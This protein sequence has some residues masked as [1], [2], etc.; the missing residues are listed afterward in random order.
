[1]CVRAWCVH[2]VTR[3]RRRVHAV[4]FIQQ[5]MLM[6]HVVTSFAVPRS[7]QSFLRVRN[8]DAHPRNHCCSGMSVAFV[9]QHEKHLRHIII[10]GLWLHYI[11]FTLSHKRHVFRKKTLLNIKCV[12]RFSLQLLC[13]TLVILRRIQRDIVT[14]VKTFSCKIPVIIVGF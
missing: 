14:N 4:V 13:E 3:A 6:R 7:R 8:T 1:M 5:E 12:S 10:C 11:F 2:V 9:V